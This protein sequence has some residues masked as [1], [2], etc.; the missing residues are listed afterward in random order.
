LLRKS[1]QHH[2]WQ[3]YLRSWSDDGQV[4]CLQSD[5]LFR[6]G[7]PV[8]GVATDFYKVP[9][10]TDEDLSLIHLLL[11]LDKVHPIARKHHEMV[12]Q[13]ILSPSLFVQQHRGELKH[14]KQ[15]DELLDFYNTNAV[16]NHH[17]AIE[18][19]FVPLLAPTLQADVEWYQNDQHC[20]SFCNFIAAQHMRTRNVKEKTIARLKDRVGLDIS[21]VWNILGLI[22]GFNIGC[23]LFLERKRRRLILLQNDTGMQF[24]TGDQ[25]LINLHG[26]GESPP[27][28]LSFYYPLSPRLALYLGEPEESPVRSFDALTADAVLELNLRIARASHS[29]TYAHAADSL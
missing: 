7:T 1:R 29:Q 25:P 18:S 16:D 22:L 15:I 10:L 13:N 20:I 24:I 14:L 11:A 26:D 28:S 3:Q 5:R 12:L 9:R 4:C 23:A 8:L 17:T 19:G 21:R 2:V 6:T 27:E